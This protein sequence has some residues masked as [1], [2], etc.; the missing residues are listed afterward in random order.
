MRRGSIVVL[1]RQM[2]V[3]GIFTEVQFEKEPVL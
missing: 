2:G 1:V 3:G